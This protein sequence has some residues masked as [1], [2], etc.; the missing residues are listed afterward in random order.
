MGQFRASSVSSWTV[1]AALVAIACVTFTTGVC[2]AAGSALPS[3][4]DRDPTASDRLPATFEGFRSAFGGGPAYDSRRVATLSGTK[5]VWT[6]FIFKQRREQ[7]VNVCLFIFTRSA[8]TGGGGAGGGCSPSNKFFGTGGNVA[9]SATG[10]VLAGVTSDHVARVQ[11]IGS[12]GKVHALRLTPDKG[13]IFNCRAYN[14]CACVIAR[15]EAYDRR[16]NRI[17][18]QDWRSS[19]PNCRR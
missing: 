5:H 7:R 14:G 2:A 1:R 17:E 6:V 15:L 13:F 12:L 9:A 10:R 18:A 11:V 3:A 19:A 4:F 16:G 8:R